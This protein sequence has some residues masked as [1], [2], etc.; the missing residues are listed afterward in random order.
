MV[1]AKMYLE[2]IATTSWGK[3]VKFRVVTRGEDNKVWSA[4]TPT[5]EMA[6]TIKN[7][8]AASRFSDTDVGREFFVDISPV[9]DDL[10]GEE[11][12]G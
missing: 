2:E 9:P 3:R 11:G 8:K 1:R 7:E 6:F 12:M 10:Q 5:G 4:A